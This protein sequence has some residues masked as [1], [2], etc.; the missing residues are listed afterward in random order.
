MLLFS[1]FVLPLSAQ[2]RTQFE[3]SIILKYKEAEEKIRDVYRQVLASHL[4]DTLFQRNLTAAQN[5]WYQYRDAQINVRFPKQ[6]RPENDSSN[7]LYIYAYKRQL[8]E[9]RIKELQS[10]LEN[11]NIPQ[12]VE[13]QTR[14]IEW[15][16]FPD[17]VTLAASVHK[18]IIVVF[19]SEK[20]TADIVIKERFAMNGK[21]NNYLLDHFQLVSI[22]RSH[23][24]YQKQ[25]NQD[26]LSQKISG[27]GA[28]PAMVF[29]D[30]QGD[31]IWYYYGGTGDET[32]FRALE[33]TA[34]EFYLK[35]SFSDYSDDIK[36]MSQNKRSVLWYSYDE[37]MKMAAQSGKKIIINA[38]AFWSPYCIRMKGNTYSKDS[39]IDYITSHFIPIQIETM[40]PETRRLTYREKK[41][42]SFELLEKIYGVTAYPQTVFCENDG[43]KID[44]VSGFITPDIF[45]C[46]LKYFSEE[47]YKIEEIHSYFDRLG[48]S[49]A[50]K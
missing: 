40:I 42:G 24:E 10:Y 33:Y 36:R 49:G 31:R 27:V 2:L 5:I 11:G 6:K 50:L 26:L 15:K 23:S 9:A 32:I 1:L 21:I 16:S 30:E 7:I 20:S 18:K 37:G 46:V 28:D 35:Q 25:R 17:A 22:E 41:M 4:Q 45:L 43:T 12:I 47:R 48:M 19:R 8:T 13:P 38:H 34:G 3:V 14:T 29:F 39:V 44:L